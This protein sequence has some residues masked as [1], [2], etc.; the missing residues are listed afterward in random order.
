ML[1]RYHVNQ[2]VADCRDV[3]FLPGGCDV[4]FSADC[5]VVR[6]LQR[7]DVVDGRGGSV[8]VDLALCLPVATDLAVLLLNH[9]RL[10]AKVATL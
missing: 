9:A 6:L 4:Q 8:E 5:R 10:F 3:L 1:L 7:E 2:V